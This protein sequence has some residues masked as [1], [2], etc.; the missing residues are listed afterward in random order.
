M[1]LPL[2]QPH[3]SAADTGDLHRLLHRVA[4]EEF[5]HFLVENHLEEDRDSLGLIRKRWPGDDVMP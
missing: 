4:A 5:A 3:I 1:L 2:P